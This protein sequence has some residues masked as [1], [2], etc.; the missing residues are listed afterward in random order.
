MLFISWT[1][2]HLSGFWSAVHSCDCDLILIVTSQQ[3]VLSGSRFAQIVPLRPL[4]WWYSELSCNKR[5]ATSGVSCVPCTFTVGF[6]TT[7]TWMY[8]VA[9]RPVIWPS[10]RPCRPR[11]GIEVY[12]YAVLDEDGWA[13]PL[14][15]RFSPGEMTRWPLCTSSGQVCSVAYNV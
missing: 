3:T 9:E 7:A 14:P 11:G 8:F 4:T 15:V 5:P 1:A 2:H 10:N 6:P 12:L 13:T